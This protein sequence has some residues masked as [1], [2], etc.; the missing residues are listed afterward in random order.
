[1]I[2]SNLLEYYN[3]ILYSISSISTKDEVDTYAKTIML[4]LNQVNQPLK[5]NRFYLF[6]I[7]LVGY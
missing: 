3:N 6:R 7:L 5:Y 2:L 4:I 1:M